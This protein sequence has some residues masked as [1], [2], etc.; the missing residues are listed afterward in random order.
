MGIGIGSPVEMR[1]GCTLANT[2]PRRGA[3]ERLEAVIG[4]ALT[5]ELNFLRYHR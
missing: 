2:L 3:M 1:E 4:K 5:R